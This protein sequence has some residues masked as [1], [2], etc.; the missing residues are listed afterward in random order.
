MK[1]IERLIISFI[2]LSAFMNVC[3]GAAK[4]CGCGFSNKCPYIKPPCYKAIFSNVIN[5]SDGNYIDYNN[6]VIL[7]YETDPYED[8]CIWTTLYRHEVEGCIAILASSDFNTIHV[9]GKDGENFLY[10]GNKKKDSDR[11][12]L[13]TERD[14]L[15][16]SY[17]SPCVDAGVRGYG[18]KVTYE[19]VWDCSKCDNCDDLS[20]KVTYDPNANG[21]VAYYANEK[22]CP[23]PS[24][25]QLLTVTMSCSEADYIKPED[26]VI[27]VWDS[28]SGSWILDPSQKLVEAWVKP[29]ECFTIGPSSGSSV[30]FS[31]QPKKGRSPA[32]A[33][34]KCTAHFFN[35]GGQSAT[36]TVYIK[37]LPSCTPCCYI[38]TGAICVSDPC[39]P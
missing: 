38:C 27:K 34:V 4:D 7:R 1:S 29:R 11:P 24:S 15:G 31:I 5:C 14:C 26:P 32:K 23:V 25:G 9:A 3:Y 28:N 30:E 22:C 35:E 8:D 17:S 20:I 37:V 36:K 19:P 18:G 13:Y 39:C 12:N 16:A 6:P 2:F 33:R 10:V 21:P